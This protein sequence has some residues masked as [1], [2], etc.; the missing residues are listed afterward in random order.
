MD[1]LPSDVISLIL[2]S[3]AIDEA[4]RYILLNSSS[5]PLLSFN[6][7]PSSTY[8]TFDVYSRLLQLDLLFQR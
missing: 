2:S 6:E 1:Q 7:N 3:L 8:N 5:L 4:V